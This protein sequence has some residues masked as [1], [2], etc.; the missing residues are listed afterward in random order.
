MQDS[1]E[2]EDEYYDGMNLYDSPQDEED[3]E[4][5]G[6]DEHVPMG[7]SDEASGGSRPVSVQD[8]FQLLINQFSEMDE[9]S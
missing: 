4:D 1:N 2:S 3:D 6:E 9:H 8:I 5:G 7:S